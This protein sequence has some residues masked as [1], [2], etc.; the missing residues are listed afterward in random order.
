MVVVQILREKVSPNMYS[1]SS[2][3]KPKPKPKPKPNGGKN[4]L[5]FQVKF[6]QILHI[7]MVATIVRL[8]GNMISRSVL[9]KIR[10]ATISRKQPSIDWILQKASICHRN[11]SHMKAAAY[12]KLAADQGY[13]ALRRRQKSPK[14]SGQIQAISP[15]SDHNFASVRFRCG[16]RGNPDRKEA[17]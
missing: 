17:P 11:S 6:R 8:A 13:A 3:P 10:T 12:Y 14:F 5:N 7:L 1:A 9:D 15:Y 16:A 4:H 2:A